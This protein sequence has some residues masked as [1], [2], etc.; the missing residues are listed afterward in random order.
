MEIP[1]GSLAHDRRRP[2]RPAINQAQPSLCLAT[3]ADVTPCE[4]SHL[5]L[6]QK[7]ENF[8]FGL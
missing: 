5:S 1:R 7:D 4:K 6:A 3:V 8:T 2:P